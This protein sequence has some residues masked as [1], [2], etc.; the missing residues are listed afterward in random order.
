MDTSHTKLVYTGR[1]LCSSHLTDGLVYIAWPLCF[2]FLRK[3]GKTFSAVISN[4]S[5]RRVQYRT[6]DAVKGD[7]I[8]FGKRKLNLHSRDARAT[9]NYYVS[10]YYTCT[11]RC[12]FVK[13]TQLSLLEVRGQ[14][15]EGLILLN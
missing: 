9:G 12:S 10:I 7:R 14:A 3:L 6:I 11:A 1:N 4:S 15:E 13:G 5:E 8:A 2:Y